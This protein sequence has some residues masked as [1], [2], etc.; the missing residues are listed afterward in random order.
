MTLYEREAAT[1]TLG[2]RFRDEAFIGQKSILDG[3][4]IW[5]REVFDELYDAYVQSPDET[6]RSFDEKL[7]DQLADVSS[8][9]RQVF[10]EL[11]L[12]QMIP[13]RRMRADTKLGRVRGVLKGCV[14]PFEMPDDVI[15]LVNS[16]GVFSGGQGYYRQRYVH[17]WILVELGREL[18]AL[19]RED[20]QLKLAPEQIECTLATLPEH[21]NDVFER[22][23]CYL[24][25]PQHFPT[26]VSTGHLTQIVD[27]FTNEFLPGEAR[28]LSL[29]RKT[30][31][32][33]DNIRA[34]RGSDWTFYLDRD[35]WMNK[36]AAAEP[37]VPVKASSEAEPGVFS[38]PPFQPDA[39]T[40][41]NV[42]D[43]WLQ[44][45][46]RLL[47]E[48]KQIILAGPPGTGKTYL[49]K[50]IAAQLAKTNVT[51]VQFHPSY[52]YEEFFQGYRPSGTSG[53]G[54]TLKL[55]D[56]PL[57]TI[58]AEASDNQEEPYFLVIDE[59]NRGNLAQVFG[60][61]YFLLEYRDDEVRLMYSDEPFSIPENLF[62]IGT[63]NTADRSI[64]L[65]D[66]A[67]RRRFAF[68]EL[69]PD[70]A[71]TKDLL[72]TWEAE[73]KP[74]LPVNALW[75]ELNRRLVA[76]NADRNSLIGPSYFMRETRTDYEGLDLT[77]ET[78]I[79]PLLDEIFLDEHERVRRDFALDAL[80]QVVGITSED[81]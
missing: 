5:T 14:P 30:K 69:H 15:E 2:T 67:I 4:R 32:I 17:L 12:L 28:E 76:N 53:S 80:L 47:N 54:L 57:R 21:R 29:P 49:A 59:I 66:A 13:E 25:A 68:I 78:E 3:R 31:I 52:G 37:A 48:K 50:R 24:F 51:F 72:S 65:V 75:Q 61:L 77:W 10:A 16:S 6:N 7:T 36:P 26:T 56:G 81:G 58:A 70:T 9:A 40:L 11:Y 35:E 27:H 18:M 43:K 34:Q 19:S 23:L 42:S 73:H 60:E 63:M 38:L 45:V 20:R 1:E 8:N 64:A 71:P 22:T 46:W 33:E 44:R 39:H 79:F 55:V 74:E 41:L 62:I